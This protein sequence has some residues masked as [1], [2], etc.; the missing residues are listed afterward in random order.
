MTGN[1]QTDAPAPELATPEAPDIVVIGAGERLARLRRRR[2]LIREEILAV[3]V[4]LLV[5]GVT[6]AVLAT[7]WLAGSSAATGA[8]PLHPTDIAVPY[9]GTT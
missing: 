1:P 9:G 7:Q 5:L 3:A 6:V 2:R 4:L 8:A